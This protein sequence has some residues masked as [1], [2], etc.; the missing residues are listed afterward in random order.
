MKC[1]CPL[2]TALA[3]ATELAAG[4]VGARH[5]E[6]VAVAADEELEDE[7]DDGWVVHLRASSLVMRLSSSFMSPYVCL[8]SSLMS[9]CISSSRLATFSTAV[10][11]RITVSLPSRDRLNALPIP[12]APIVIEA[13]TAAAAISITMERCVQEQ[14][15]ELVQR[16]CPRSF[17]RPRR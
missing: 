17:L 2:V 10:V 3:G 16:P 9:T 4:D 11:R 5:Q 8:R 6:H 15:S 14:R 13:P 12:M 1:A 7:A